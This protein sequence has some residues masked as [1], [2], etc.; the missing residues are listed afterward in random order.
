MSK[1]HLSLSLETHLSKNFP[2]GLMVTLKMV[3]EN[4]KM[5]S[6]SCSQTCHNHM[7]QGKWSELSRDVKDT[8]LQMLFEMY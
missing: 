7:G 5:W 6:Q 1:Q 8:A 4:T 2:E 3:L